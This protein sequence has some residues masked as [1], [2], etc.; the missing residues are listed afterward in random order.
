MKKREQLYDE[1]YRRMDGRMDGRR[2]VDLGRDW[3]I[4][5]DPAGR[6]D[7]QAIQEIIVRSQNP[8]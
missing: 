5:G 2:D 8:L 3:R 6:G 1:P 7:Y 4:G